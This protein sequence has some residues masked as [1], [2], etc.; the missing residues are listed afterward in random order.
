[1][2]IRMHPSHEFNSLSSLR[3]D[4][5]RQD[6]AR[7]SRVLTTGTLYMVN[8]LPSK[9]HAAAPK[10]PPLLLTTA[11]HANKINASIKQGHIPTS[12]RLQLY[13]QISWP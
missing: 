11:G 8:T 4:P 7:T 1:M 3:E 2:R 13:S 6:I 12:T 9:S 5:I 10:S